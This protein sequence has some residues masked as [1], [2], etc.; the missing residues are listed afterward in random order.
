MKWMLHSKQAS[1]SCTHFKAYYCFH[2]QPPLLVFPENYTTV[3][4]SKWFILTKGLVHVYVRHDWIIS[5]S[6][7]VNGRGGIPKQVDF[8]LIVMSQRAMQPH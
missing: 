3:Y 1:S 8:D 4:M 2:A 7:H 6:I 5:F